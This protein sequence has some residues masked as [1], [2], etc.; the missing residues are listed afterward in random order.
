MPASSDEITTNSRH[1]APEK[2]ASTPLLTVLCPAYNHEKYIEAAF[3]GFLCQKVNF[4][5][6]IIVHDDA[7][8]DNTRQIIEEYTNKHPSTIE[9]IL[10]LKNQYSQGIKPIG[11]MLKQARGK[12]IALCEGDDYWTDPQKLQKQVD[13]LETRSDYAMCSHELDFIYDGIEPEPDYYGKPILDASFDDIIM[14]QMFIGF[15]SI[16]YRRNCLPTLPA[17]LNELPGIH[18]AMVLLLTSKG[19]NHHFLER[20]AVKQRN[21]GGAT[22]RNKE[23]RKRNREEYQIFLFENLK[24]ELEGK[25]NQVINKKLC[26]LYLRA[27]MKQALRLYFIRSLFYLMKFIKFT[28]ERLSVL[29]QKN[30]QAID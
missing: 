14:N 25:K 30:P 13:F 15:N 5:F 27:S 18:K 3:E 21:P 2:R 8:S 9:P 28:I 12:Y 6:E 20:M 11:L 29:K 16:V 10:Q 4:D 17:W 22:I 23:W 7:S 26:R 24:A 1:D 19:K